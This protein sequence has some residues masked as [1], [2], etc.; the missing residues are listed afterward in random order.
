MSHPE[1]ENEP[2]GVFNPRDHPKVADPVS[3]KFAE[4]FALHRLAVRTRVIERSDL[5]AK[6]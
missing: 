3:P 6:V 4:A 5:V 1:H 2:L